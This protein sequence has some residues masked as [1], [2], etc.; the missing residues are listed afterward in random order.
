MLRTATIAFAALA[1][2]VIAGCAS[3]P[4]RTAGAQNLPESQLALIRIPPSTQLTTWRGTPV[5]LKS[6]WIGDTEYLLPKDRR[7][8]VRP[9]TY[10]FTV[11]Y[12][13]S[14]ATIGSANPFDESGIFAAPFGRWQQEVKAGVTYD[15]VGTA[16]PASKTTEIQTRH[17]LK[18]TIA[19]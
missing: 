12:E 16:E 19:P 15:L 3:G 17:E 10:Q 14:R 7:F 6:I 9:G 11:Q 5:D 4:T 2:F 13:K 18:P 8:L 1:L